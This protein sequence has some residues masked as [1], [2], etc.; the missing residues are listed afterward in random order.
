MNK[1]L[2]LELSDEALRPRLRVDDVSGSALLPP[3]GQMVVANVKFTRNWPACLGGLKITFK[4]MLVMR[5]KSSSNSKGW[6]WS[7]C[8]SESFINGDVVSWHYR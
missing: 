2:T 3:M 1:Q 5:I 7:G 8:E 4:E 6:Q